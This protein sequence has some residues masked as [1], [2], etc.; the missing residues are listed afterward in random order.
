MID[1]TNHQNG[2]FDL[3]RH[4]VTAQELI[5]LLTR[6]RAQGARVVFTNGCFDLLHVG[7]IRYLQSA[8]ALGDLLVVG[9]NSDASVHG[10]QKGRGRPVIPAS[11]RME[12][13]SALSCVDYVVTFEEPDPLRLIEILQP[14]VLAKGGDWPI[15]QI[16]GRHSVEA[17]GGAVISIPLIPDVSTSRLIE[18]IQNLG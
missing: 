16:V 9:V 4:V 1:G 6:R 11:Q 14:D 7:H 2:P 3:G 13:L 10:L 18:R 15:E 12:V 5:P 8:R 17:R